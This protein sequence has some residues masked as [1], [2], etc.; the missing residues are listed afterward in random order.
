MPTIS[1]R[2]SSPVTLTPEGDQ[3]W[4][5]Q[6]LAPQ[7]RDVLNHL[8]QAGRREL[9]VRELMLLVND[10]SSITED[11]SELARNGWVVIA[12]PRQLAD[13][14]EEGSAPLNAEAPEEALNNLLER[15]SPTPLEVVPAAQVSS[16]EVPSGTDMAAPTQERVVPKSAIEVR[17]DPERDRRLLEA[18]GILKGPEEAS[19]PVVSA[20]PPEARPK[21]KD[22]HGVPLSS[23]DLLKRL[24]KLPED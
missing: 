18:M 7:L 24:G 13:P 10:S 2:S 22:I 4:R 15:R 8:R 9:L 21:T 23:R 16:T 1:I 17:S 14:S 3:A 5:T 20:P 12:L 19:A 6:N 11:L